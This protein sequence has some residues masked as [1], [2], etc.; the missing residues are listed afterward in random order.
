MLPLSSL[1]TATKS[2]TIIVTRRPKKTSAG[3]FG[4]G[5]ETGQYK[6]KHIGWIFDSNRTDLG[7]FAFATTLVLNE[8]TSR[9]GYL[10]TFREVS[11]F[12]LEYSRRKCPASEISL[13]GTRR[14]RPR[15]AAAPR[16]RHFTTPDGLVPSPPPAVFIA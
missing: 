3:E 16:T 13:V 15:A 6:M 2:Q 8:D 4:R 7:R 1:P 5:L 9:N 10:C 12:R 11:P 14:F